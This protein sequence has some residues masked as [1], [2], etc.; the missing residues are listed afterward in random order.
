MRLGP[1]IDGRLRVWHLEKLAGANAVLTVFPN[2]LEAFLTNYPG[3]RIAP[4]IE[5]PVPE[6]VLARLSRIPYFIEAYDENGLAPEQFV[7]HP[8][9]QATAAS[10]A[11][12][13]AK[14]ERFA[15]K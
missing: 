9:L 13:M 14:V 5:E 7:A 10:F 3:L 11:D 1:T 4:Q 8:A 15:A 2:I 6:D 12:A